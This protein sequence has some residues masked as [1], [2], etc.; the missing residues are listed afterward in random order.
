M[1]IGAL[2]IFDELLLKALCVGEFVNGSGNSFPSGEFRG[3]VTPRPG[4]KF[5]RACFPPGNG[6]TKTGCRT[7]CSRM[8][9]DN[10]ASFASSNWRRGFVFDS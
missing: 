10:S 8:L 7:P 4:D 3:A 9:S 5:I 1:D 2:Q 6:R